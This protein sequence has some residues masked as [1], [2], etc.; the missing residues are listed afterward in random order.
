MSGRVESQREHRRPV[1]EPTV[2]RCDVTTMMRRCESWNDCALS[3]GKR[4]RAHLRAQGHLDQVQ[5]LLFRGLMQG[6]H[7]ESPLT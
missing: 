3:A 4:V 6:P 5:E 7:V 2:E 1:E